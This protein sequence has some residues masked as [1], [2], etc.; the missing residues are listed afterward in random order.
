M[1][2]YKLIDHT[3]DI[4]IFVEGHDLK[5]LF[6]TAAYA[7][8]SQMLELNKVK[9]KNTKRIELEGEN[10]EDLLVRWLNE[11]LFLSEK[12]YIFKD[13]NIENLQETFLSASVKGEKIDFRKIPLKQEI[14]AATYHQL[15]IAKNTSGHW[16]TTIIFDV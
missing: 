10:L 1:G 7:M 13:F 4:G 6:A 12:G 9:G 3:A 14:K 5:D 11:L 16:Q 8:L 15:E 2:Q